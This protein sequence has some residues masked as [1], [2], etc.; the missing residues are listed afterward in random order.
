MSAATETPRD[1]HAGKS[2]N[3]R[4]GNHATCATLKARCSCSC[5]GAGG[6]EYKRDEFGCPDCAQSFSTA[7]RLGSHRARAHG[8]RAPGASSDRQTPPRSSGE[9]PTVI[10]ELVDEEPP[11]PP[12]PK[13]KPVEQI[14][15]LCR[16]AAEGDEMMPGKWKRVALFSTGRAAKAAATKLRR[17]DEL[18]FDWQAA[19][20][21]RLFVRIPEA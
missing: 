2:T 15:A 19:D 16:S 13:L 8:Y 18:G 7:Q 1:V 21:G 12:A 5:H 3:C 6:Q 17:W 11:P 4:A 14:V 9:R 20:D 10:V